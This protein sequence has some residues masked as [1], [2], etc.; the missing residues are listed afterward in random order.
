MS[1]HVGL[2]MGLYVASAMT[3]AAT[4]YNSYTLWRIDPY[5]K[6]KRTLK[7]LKGMLQKQT[8]DDWTADEKKI[9]EECVRAASLQNEL[10]E[11]TKAL[12]VNP[13]FQTLISQIEARSG[14]EGVDASRPTREV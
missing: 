9:A 8:L 11:T 14:K 13:A 6:T 2:R 3:M 5:D 10:V 4:A 7:S 12:Y 1:T